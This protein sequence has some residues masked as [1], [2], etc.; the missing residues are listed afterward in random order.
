MKKTSSNNNKIIIAV[1]VVIA[2]CFC[3]TSFLVTI[4]LF[5]S[6]TPSTPTNPAAIRNLK[7]VDTF[8][9]YKYGW[10]E[11]NKTSDTSGISRKIT[12][13][14][15]LWSL[16]NRSKETIVIMGNPTIEKAKSMSASVE[17][18]QKA[19]G[20]DVNYV[21]LSYYNDEK[22]FYSFKVNQYYQQY[23]VGVAENGKWKDL[24]A[25]KSDAVV[26]WDKPNTLK[27]VCNN[28]T[29]TFYI[30][31]VEVFKTKDTTF[32]SGGIALSAQVQKKG[33]TGIWEFD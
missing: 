22:N 4:F 17:V 24:L 3:C 19:G 2:F 10:D 31:G 29:Q 32:T 5:S 13:G 9:N 15:Y 7:F 8:D 16:E 21:L 12:G 25:W 28:G 11:V 1:V 26:N 33:V 27:V 23:T 18:N 14:K 30:N 20:A 6:S